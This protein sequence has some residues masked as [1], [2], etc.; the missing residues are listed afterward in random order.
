MPLGA[1]PKGIKYVVTVHDLIYERFPDLYPALDRKI[2]RGKTLSAFLK[3][4]KI[5]AISEQTKRDLVQFYHIDAAKIEVVYQDCDPQ[6]SV[7]VSTE[8]KKAVQAKY[9]L[10]AHFLLSVGT[11]ETRKNTKIILQALLQLPEAVKLV[12]VGKPT[13][14]AGALKAFITQHKLEHRVQLLHEVSFAELPALYQL[15]EIFIYPSIFEGF[16]IPVIEA[17]KSA[18]PVIAAT[19][20]CLEEAGG[21]GSLYFDPEDPDALAASIL[22]LWRQADAKQLQVA[23]GLNYAQKFSA[24]QFASATMA[25]Y[26]TTLK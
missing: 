25:V 10:P 13:S 7:P 20:S 21:P 3:A 6:F 22:K 4:D 17:L 2:Y 14:Y 12:L 9:A 1:K 26:A 18:V 15:S 8:I 19:G 23:E 24:A 16:G 11:L 5:I